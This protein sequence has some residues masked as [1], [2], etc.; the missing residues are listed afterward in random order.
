MKPYVTEYFAENVFTDSAMRAYLSAEAYAALR[1]TIDE[2]AP[3]T[4]EL[5]DQV[6]AAMREW[7][8]GLGATHY[9]HWF[10]PMTGQTAEKHDAF[11]S[12]GRNR[13]RSSLILT[14]KS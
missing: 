2:G 12:P 4:I 13:A 9:T 14:A 11:L 7:A 3:L 1:R 5:A 6:A 8:V 10:Q